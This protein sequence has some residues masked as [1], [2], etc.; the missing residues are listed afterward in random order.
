MK[1]RKHAKEV[2]HLYHTYR[3][4][5]AHLDPHV[6]DLTSAAILAVGASLLEV[7]LDIREAKEATT[8]KP[9]RSGTGGF[10]GL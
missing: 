7:L 10:G 3:N 8:T 4:H 6:L 1:A 2:D 9:F 5:V